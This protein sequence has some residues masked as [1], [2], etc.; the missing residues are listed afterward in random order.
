[1]FECNRYALEVSP[2]LPR[3]N[4]QI[5]SLSIPVWKTATR[6][7]EA[8]RSWTPQQ[9]NKSDPSGDSINYDKLGAQTERLPGELQLHSCKEQVQDEVEGYSVA[10]RKQSR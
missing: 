5:T 2:S 10:Q 7:E 9:A 6:Q 3:T 4:E 8:I 1:M